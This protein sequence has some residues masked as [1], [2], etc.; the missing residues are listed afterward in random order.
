L[1]Q[2]E[3][4]APIKR[5][6]PKS[7]TPR[8]AP[9]A[10]RLSYKAQRERQALRQ[11]LETLPQR[12]EALES[13]QHQ[14]TQAMATAEFYKQPAGEIAQAYVRLRSLADELAAA[15]ARWEELDRG[16]R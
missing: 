11:E 2:H 9:D 10:E 5:E 8:R 3:T 1:R 13:A 16:M 15:Y 7:E 4:A 14:L 6:Q 12:I